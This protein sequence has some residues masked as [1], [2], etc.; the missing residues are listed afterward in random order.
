MKLPHYRGYISEDRP[1]DT[2]PYYTLNTTFTKN[3]KINATDLELFFKIY[4]INNEF[5]KD[6]DK[7]P[8]RDAGY[9]Y[10]P[11]KPRT[12]IFGIKYKM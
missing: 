8:L 1:E 9:T 7:G 3:L 12:Y 6:I 11:M 5:Q 4:N 10:G 2:P